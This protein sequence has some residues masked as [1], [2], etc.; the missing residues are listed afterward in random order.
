MAEWF[1]GLISSTEPSLRPGLQSIA[2]L[3]VW[4]VWCE[5]N[6]RVFRKV[7][8][9]VGQIIYSIQDE[10]RTWAFAGTPGFG[11]AAARL[12]AWLLGSSIGCVISLM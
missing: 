12:G 8:R 11:Y 2:M 4:E 6:N 3:V 9:T 10:A 7:A 1:T 5:R